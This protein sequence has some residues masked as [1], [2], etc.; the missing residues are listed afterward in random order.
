MR[1]NSAGHFPT[2]ELFWLAMKVMVTSTFFWGHICMRSPTL[3]TIHVEYGMRP[4]H[5]E[6]RNA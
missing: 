5:V 4:E 6:G 3:L 1:P 2:F